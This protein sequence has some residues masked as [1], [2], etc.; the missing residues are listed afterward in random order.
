[1]RLH[2]PSHGAL[3]QQREAIGA[4]L[5]GVAGGA[6]CHIQTVVVGLF[7]LMMPLDEPAAAGVFGVLTQ[8]AAGSATL[9]RAGG[10]S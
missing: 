3:W 1:M 2:L 9:T 5:R 6:D 10:L 7:C 8:L 4:A